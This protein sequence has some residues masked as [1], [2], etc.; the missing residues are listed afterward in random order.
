MSNNIKE[1]KSE[2]EKL[3]ECFKEMKREFDIETER[4]QKEAE[5]LKEK[6]EQEFINLVY[7]SGIPVSVG[8]KLLVLDKKTNKIVELNDSL[9]K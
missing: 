8:N 9:P 2:K 1:N 7:E 5:L 4:L 3:D 6:E